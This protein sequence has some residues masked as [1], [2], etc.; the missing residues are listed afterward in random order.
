MGCMLVEIAWP[1]L[2]PLLCSNLRVPCHPTPAQV[3]KDYDFTNKK[4]MCPQT[5]S[6]SAGSS[7]AAPGPA[8]A[9]AGAIPSTSGTQPLTVELDV[10]GEAGTEQ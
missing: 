3:S 10:T 7:G 9:G 1:S 2:Q 5:T 4:Y 6:P 8:A